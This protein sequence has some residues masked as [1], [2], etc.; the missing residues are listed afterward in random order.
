[1]T[2]MSRIPASPL[3][4]RDNYLE[5]EAQVQ[6]RPAP[7]GYLPVWIRRAK[8]L[9]SIITPDVDFDQTSKQWRRK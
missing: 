5:K 8:R 7:I 4:K 9:L 1:M 2:K 6:R 3:R